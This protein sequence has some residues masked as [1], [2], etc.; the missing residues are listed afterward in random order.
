MRTK[1]VFYSMAIA[2]ILGSCTAEEFNTTDNGKQ[3]LSTRPLLGDIELSVNDQAQT[4]FGLGEGDKAQPVFVDG[5]ML[6]AAIIDAPN[7]LTG[8]SYNAN[9]PIENYNIVEYYS[10]NNAFT[11][12]NGIWTVD[13][14]MVEGNYLFYAPYNQKMQQR[15]PLSIKLPVKQDASSEK[16]ALSEFYNSGAVVRLGYQFLAAK[17]GEA[18]KPEVDMCDVFA[19]PLFTIQNNFN[20][21]LVDKNHQNGKTYSGTIR[22]DSIQISQVETSTYTANAV[23]CGGVLKHA[24]TSQTGANA[25][26][27]V[28][29]LMK[30]GGAWA[31][32]PMAN[33]TSQL[34]STSVTGCTGSG[35]SVTADR[36]AGVITTLDMKG[37]EIAKG[38]AYKF[39][40]VLPAMKISDTSN[41]LRMTL[42][43]TIEGK[44]YMI[45]DAT[46]TT[47]AQGG[48]SS[49]AYA[50]EG[51]LL[52]STTGEINLVKGQKYP[53]EELN[54]DGSSLTAKPSKGSIL[55]VNMQGGLGSTG[56]K[57]VQI[58]T[59]IPEVAPVTTIANN[60]EFIQFF[61]DQLN[62]SALVEQGTSVDG[63]NFA[64]SA[65]TTAKIDSE[66][67]EALYTY[68]NKGSLQIDRGLVIDNDVKVKTIGSQSGDHTPVTFVSANGTEYEIK[69]KTNSGDY[70]TT[71]SVLQ[72]T[73]SGNT[74]SVHVTTG[75]TY[76]VSTATTV[77]NLR[78]DG[79][80]VINASQTLTPTSFINNGT[81]TVNG[82]VKNT[83]TNNGT[84]NIE[85]AAASVTVNAGTGVIEVEEANKAANVTVLGGTQTGIYTVSTFS[86]TTV[87][88]GDAIAWINAIKVSGNAAFDATV[89]AAMKDIKTV[90]ATS[91]SFV[92]GTYNMLGKTLALTGSSKSITGAGRTTTTVQNITILNTEAG[93]VTLT[94]IAATG[95]YANA[96]GVNAKI[97]ADGTSATWN[98]GKAE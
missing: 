54:F 47:T 67:I 75:A 20:G 19:Y 52:N 61:K 30:E 62:G 53:Q 68:N 58:A 95:I 87:K 6:G 33:Y 5:D 45:E 70:S 22:L 85:N 49:A 78:N 81:L 25:D 66:L 44:R 88:A 7:Y 1:H 60:A 83:V 21:Y 71:S 28:V 9:S 84:I 24:G 69:L 26:A 32:S 46:V 79:T 3:D 37:K 63:A 97:I 13:Q 2:A 51:I 93:N 98:G 91:A 89:I 96:A 56:G 73:H 16:A 65:N 90:Y 36:T 29:G 27:G 77:G 55:T 17:N 40:A 38:D 43:V 23:V 72:S 50:R 8:G 94:D 31:T 4:R 41:R 92:A 76:T 64:F 39:Y 42:F 15:T 80:V 14:P 10:S 11:L 18:Q 48:Y 57:A 82:T 74:L 12:N 86:E 59:E 34:L 35:S